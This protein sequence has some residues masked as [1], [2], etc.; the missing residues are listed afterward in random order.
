MARAKIT[1]TCVVEYE[2]HPEY[3][4]T[5]STLEEMLACDINNADE[6]PFMFLG[7]DN[8]DITVKGELV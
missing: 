5:G 3:Y 1:I 6:D 7:M 4:S 8:A 2:I